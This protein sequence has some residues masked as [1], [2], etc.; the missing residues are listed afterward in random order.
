MTRLRERNADIVK[1]LD[2]LAEVEETAG[3]ISRRN[4]KKFGELF[5]VIVNKEGLVIDGRHRLAACK[6]WKREIVDL[7]D[8]YSCL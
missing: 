5:P 6:N 2:R 1:A 7:D 4:G 8:H 3:L